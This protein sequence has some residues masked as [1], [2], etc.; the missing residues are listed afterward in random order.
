MSDDLTHLCDPKDMSAEYIAQLTH[1]LYAR[2]FMYPNSKELHER[3]MAVKA[4]VTRR[5]ADLSRLTAE[6]ERLKGELDQIAQAA[7][8]ENA[9]VVQEGLPHLMKAIVSDKHKAELDLTAAKDAL[10]VA[11]EKCEAIRQ[12]N[13]SSDGGSI[14]MAGRRSMISDLLSQALAAIR[15]VL[16]EGE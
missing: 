6:N 14:I 13:A 9:S 3:A 4:E 7:G 1:E 5:L 2:T 8:F 11:E 15:A 16:K 12:V 10:R